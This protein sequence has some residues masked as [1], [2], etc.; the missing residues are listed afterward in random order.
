M[1]WPPKSER[2][3]DAALGG[4]R[5]FVD[6]NGLS[7]REAIGIFEAETNLVSRV[8]GPRIPSKSMT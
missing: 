8:E 5:Q 7:W 3:E 1:R 6:L 4:N 2:G